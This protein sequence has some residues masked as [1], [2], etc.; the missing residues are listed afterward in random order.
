MSAHLREAIAI[1]GLLL[2]FVLTNLFV[3]ETK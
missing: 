1:V 3:K 2:L